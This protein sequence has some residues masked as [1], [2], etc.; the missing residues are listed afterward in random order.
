MQ[1]KLCNVFSAYDWSSLK[2]K[3][4]A[5]AA[6]D[7]LNVTLTQAVYLAQ[8]FLLVTLNSINVLLGFLEN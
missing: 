4:F 8:L 5:G 2:K 6:I 7:R 1:C 3:T